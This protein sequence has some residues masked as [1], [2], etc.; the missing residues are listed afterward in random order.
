[1]GKISPKVSPRVKDEE[2]G[3]VAKNKSSSSSPSYSNVLKKKH[4]SPLVTIRKKDH[5]SM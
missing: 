4:S 5:N 3:K 2:G 1:V